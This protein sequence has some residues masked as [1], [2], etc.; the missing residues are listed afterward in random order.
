M[1]FARAL[2]AIS[3]RDA[4]LGWSGGGG[5]ILPTAFFAGA[6]ALAPFS[7]G[8]DPSVLAKIGP[9]FLWL[10]L[11]LAALVSLERLFQADLE[12]GTLDQLALSGVPL[13]FVVAA[14]VFGQWLAAGAP[15]VAITPVLALLLQVSPLAI[16]A[17]MLNVAIGGLGLF[18]I[19]SIPAALS[20]GVQRGGLLAALLALP[21]YAPPVIFGAAAAS[22]AAIGGGLGGQP[23]LLLCAFT[24]AALATAPLA[25][26][27]SLRLHLS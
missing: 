24:L 1:S 16:P 2:I 14:K 10:A 25:A 17:L 9:G 13:T 18:F 7:I 21:L 5:A 3:M 6:A 19:G 15:L 8:P 20:A 23:F 4:R 11:A 27:A 12:D 22:A 26:T